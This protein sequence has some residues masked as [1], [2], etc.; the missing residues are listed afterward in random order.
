M[1]LVPRNKTPKLTTKV[2][3]RLCLL[4]PLSQ[5]RPVRPGGAGPTRQLWAGR[6][7][8]MRVAVGHIEHYNNLVNY[9]SGSHQ[10]W[11]L[12]RSWLRLQCLPSG[13]YYVYLAGETWV[14]PELIQ[15]SQWGDKNASC[16]R[17][18][19]FATN[20]VYIAHQ[21]FCCMRQ[22]YDI[23]HGGEENDI[24]QGLGSKLLKDSK[25]K[26]EFQISSLITG[27]AR[28]GFYNAILGVLR[29]VPDGIIHLGP[30]CS[31]F[32]WMSSSGHRRGP[33]QPYGDESKSFVNVG[34][35]RL[36]LQT[37][38]RFISCLENF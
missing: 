30:P 14:Q 27:L 11:C 21:F 24:T 9:V 4:Q 20:A 5:A 38:N 12:L 13:P 36:D 32:V 7:P 31:S 8:R 22:Y 25:S 23:T 1:L 2:T 26:H 19:L 28:I 17:F 10:L 3:L 37:S 34:S 35:Q 16:P 6:S 29:V 33:Q 18:L 15:H